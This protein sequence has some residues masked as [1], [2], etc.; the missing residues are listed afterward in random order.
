MAFAVPYQ[1]WG[2]GDAWLRRLKRPSFSYCLLNKLPTC[3]L[4]AAHANASQKLRS[5]IIQIHQTLNLTTQKAR[6]K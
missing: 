1:E 5:E 4:S 6:E 3:S 2:Q